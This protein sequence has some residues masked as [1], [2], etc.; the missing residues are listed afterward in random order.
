MSTEP[1][2]RPATPLLPLLPLDEALARLL[3]DPALCVR[4]AE[5]ARARIERDF[6]IHHNTARLRRLFEAEASHGAAQPQLG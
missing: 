3:A 5:Q 1:A 2:R 6:D 4:L